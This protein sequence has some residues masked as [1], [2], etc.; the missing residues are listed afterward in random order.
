[1]TLNELA[2]KR[3]MHLG[4]TEAEAYVKESTVTS[5]N[6][7]EKMENYKTSQTTGITLRAALGK[8]TAMYSTSILDENEVDMAATQVVKVARASPEDL[9]W[10]HMNNVFGRAK[11]EGYFDAELRNLEAKAIVEHLNSATNRMKEFDRRVKPAF[12]SLSIITTHVS[13]ENC[14]GERDERDETNILVAFHAKAEDGTAASSAAESQGARL[15]KQVDFEKLAETV[16]DKAVKC[17]RAKSLPSRKTVAVIR[18]QTFADF[19]GLMLGESVNAEAIQ[20]GRSP[21]A[22][23][24]GAEIASDMVTVVDDGFMQSG[25]NTRPFDDEGHATQKTVVVESG[26]LKNYLYDTY[27]ALKDNVES[28]GNCIRQDY[29][30]RP[31]PLPSNFI[32]QPGRVTQAEL[33]GDVQ[34]GVFIEETIGGWLSDPISGNLNATISQGYL[35]EKGELTKPIKGMVLSANFHEMMKNQIDLM[36][37]DLRNSMQYYS[38]SVRIREL[39][40]AGQN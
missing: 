32:L 27:S 2:V 40:I 22:G 10:K 37:N 15:W 31:Q 3:M 16:A 1:M 18:N 12:S 23:K 34:S 26:A 19:L 9:N 14:Y 17:L 21:F 24:L 35:I 13:I 20:N 30:M 25:W 29:W 28:T 5:V 11:A 38:P 4:A 33:I 36:G 6:F 7:A 8:R 39:T